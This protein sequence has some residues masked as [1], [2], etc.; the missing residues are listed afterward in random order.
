MLLTR[1]LE[2]DGHMATTAENG[3]EAL[4]L[5]EGELPDVILL[6][7]LGSCVYAL[8]SQSQHA[9]AGT[10]TQTSRGTPDF[11]SG[12]YDQFRHP[13]VP[14]SLDE[15]HPASCLRAGEHRF[16]RETLRALELVCR[17]ERSVRGLVEARA[18]GEV[19]RTVVRLAAPSSSR[20][21]S[22]SWSRGSEGAPA[23]C[24]SGAPHRRPGADRSSPAERPCRTG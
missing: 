6:D 24:R 5:L 23:A 1:N 20:P 18:L 12:A 3:R 21:R 22:R 8:P 10:R 4:D 16:A 14:P 2:E 19:G 13:G 9:G 17:E 11:K 15:A 7:I